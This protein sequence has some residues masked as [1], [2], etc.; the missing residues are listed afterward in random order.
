MKTTLS[1]GKRLADDE[2]ARLLANANGVP[3]VDN[4][5]LREQIAAF[6]KALTD[7]MGSMAKVTEFMEAMQSRGGGD[8]SEELIMGNTV[9]AVN[10][11]Q[12]REQIAEFAKAV[13]DGMGKGTAFDSQWTMEHAINWAKGGGDVSDALATLWNSTA[14]FHERFDTIHDKEHPFIPAQY[15]AFMEEVAEFSIE[16]LGNEEFGGDVEAVERELT[17]VIVVGMGL[18]M[19]HGRNLEDLCAAMR[20]VAQGNDAKTLDKYAKNAKGKVSKKPEVK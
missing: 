20:Y 2:A 17:D 12:L 9:P 16:V 6:A 15:R 11:E 10:D 8:V 7:G 1:A 19:A 4:D 18:L 14:E 5:Q 3:A 13:K